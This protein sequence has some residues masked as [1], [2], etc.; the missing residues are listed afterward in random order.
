MAV[1][2]SRRG[3]ALPITG[4]PE[5]SVSSGGAPRRVAVLGGDYVGMKPTM[6]VKVGDAVKRGQ[7][8][9]DDKKTAGVRYTAPG[10][11]KVGAIHR[12]ERRALQSVVIELSRGEMEGRGGD[13]VTFS[14]Y[15]GSHPSSLGRDDV[16]A[17]LLESGLWT[18]LRARPFGKVA[19]PAA[20]PHSIFVTAVDTQPLAPDPNVVLA[21]RDSDFKR[22]LAALSKLTDGTVFVCTGETMPFEVAGEAGVQV[23]QFVGPHPAGS[24]GYHIHRLD[25]VDRNKLVWHV[26]YQD[27]LAIGTLFGT[28]ELEV[29]R[30]VSLAG[31]AV[32]EPRLLRTRLG[33]E[34]ASLVDGE[35]A[36]G[37]NR[38]LS[39][40]VLSGR[41]ASGEEVGYLGRYHQIVSVLREDR[42]RS[43]LGWMGPGLNQFSVVNAFVSKLMPG[44][45]FPLTTSTN[46]SR[47][48]IVPIG[49]YEKVMPFDI[50]PTFLLKALVMGDV[51]RAEELGCLELDEDD[52][53]LCTFVC[54]GKNDY[55]PYL[56]EI[57]TTIE[58]E[59]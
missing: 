29:E 52:L 54:P 5:Q 21:G 53:A 31:P 12:G 41:I 51:E 47:R 42:E 9:F 13:A 33:A 28:G 39:G 7:V 57:L 23:E 11:G 4:Q 59:G 34:T 32:N 50:M 17:L 3:L 56:R 16:A 40:S 37:E 46:G 44:K 6:Q 15:K 35:I 36:E 25:P 2:K 14:S 58:K 19:D 10:A 43:F 8:L 1:H 24:P 48:A 30:V 20:V 27:V 49:M 22:G 26:G 38:V 18:A 45:Q 55:G